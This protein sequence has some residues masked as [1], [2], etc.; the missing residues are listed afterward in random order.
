MNAAVEYHTRLRVKVEILDGTFILFVSRNVS[1]VVHAD[2]LKITI[3]CLLTD[4]AVVGMVDKNKF[5]IALPGI[6]NQSTVRNNRH[7]WKRYRGTRD[8]KI[9]SSIDLHQTHS[10]IARY[11][12]NRVITKLGDANSLTLQY[13]QQIFLLRN[14]LDWTFI[15]KHNGTRFV[16]CILARSDTLHNCLHPASMNVLAPMQCVRHITIVRCSVR[17]EKTP[18]HQK[19]RRGIPQGKTCC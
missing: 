14:N 10:T 12:E 15:H 3:C 13:F 8:N 17:F 4:G 2:I 18:G 5:H 7:A 16:F 19:R 6:P 11:G 1:T 9:L